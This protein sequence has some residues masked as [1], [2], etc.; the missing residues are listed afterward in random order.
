MKE[1]LK[2][3]LKRIHNFQF[4]IRK[5]FRKT[6]SKNQNCILFEFYYEDEERVD[7]ILMKKITSISIDKLLSKE[8][9]ELN[10][11]IDCSLTGNGI[12]EFIITIEDN[13]V[14]ESK[15]KLDL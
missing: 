5:I 10:I 7:D 8:S 12:F 3:S 4:F 14:H 13:V 11:E 15:L 1:N 9:G 2:E 6:Q